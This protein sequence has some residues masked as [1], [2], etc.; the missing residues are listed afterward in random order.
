MHQGLVRLTFCM[1]ASA[2]ASSRAGPA[3][4]AHAPLQGLW[5]LVAATQWSAAGTPE[6][7]LGARPSGYAVFDAV[8]H[9]SVQLTR[10][11]VA[12]DSIEAAASA[13]AYTGLFGTFEI[14]T[15]AS[16]PL[17]MRVEGSNY[18][19]YIGTTQQRQFHVAGDTLVVGLPGKYELRFVRIDQSR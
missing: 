9:V 1:L 12:G 7:P 5:R 17:R 15:T 2:C 19:P 4:F 11:A 8:G 10:P 6:L 18:A 13:A 16:L 14:D 3:P